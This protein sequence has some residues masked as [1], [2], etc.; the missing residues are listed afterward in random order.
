MLKPSMKTLWAQSGAK[1]KMDDS[2]IAL[3]WTAERPPFQWENWS[4]W[5]QDAFIAHIN[6][7]GIPEWDN[8]TAYG[9]GGKS[10]TL[11]S[12]GTI[13][14]SLQPSGGSFPP[15]NPVSSPTFWTTAFL[16]SDAFLQTTGQSTSKGMSQRAIT[17][18]LANV[19]GSD[20]E[21]ATPLEQTQG[22]VDNKATT[23]RGVKRFVDANAVGE[24]NGKLLREG[25]YGI[26]SQVAVTPTSLSSS[27]F[28]GV[29]RLTG[30]DRFAVGTHFKGNSPKWFAMEGVFT[31]TGRDVFA[32]Y[33]DNSITGVD[34]EIW[35]AKLFSDKNTVTDAN[36]FIREVGYAENLNA[37]LWTS[38]VQTTGQATNKVMSQKAVTDAIGS[39]GGGVSGVPDQNGILFN[40]YVKENV[41]FESTTSE[42]YYS[43]SQY[44]PDGIRYRA[45][46]QISPTPPPTDAFLFKWN[47]S[48]SYPKL[49]I[50]SDADVL[51]IQHGDLYVPL[52]GFTVGGIATFERVIRARGDVKVDGTVF[53][54][55][56]EITSDRRLKK[57]IKV[58]ESALDKINS[59]SGNTYTLTRGGLNIPSGGVIAQ[60]LEEVEPTLVTE[61]EAGEKSVKYNGVVAL[62]VEGVKELFGKF[63]VLGGEVCKQK[64][65]IDSL[66]KE[67]ALL[68]K[69]VYGE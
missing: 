64:S 34:K 16:S 1:E 26:G 60:E 45:D 13:Y 11:G 27:G 19:G 8:G 43:S 59:I 39:G 12:N 49:S 22:V 25:A 17:D 40:N 66:R 23:P 15:S 37:L 44:N 52:G 62:L 18:A 5:R 56:V 14:V 32:V 4:Q 35:R 55:E 20:V 2:K 61:N 36:G 53:A 21:I 51:V 68:S 50:L 7:R 31:G 38:L 9:L 69:K 57:D 58:I 6:E 29:S 24:T 42:D 33:G 48:G 28:V 10:Y 67:V 54:T 46:S 30:S 63:N 65:E 3:G 41:V 47:S